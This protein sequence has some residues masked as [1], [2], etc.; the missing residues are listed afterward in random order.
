MT[1]PKVWTFF[2]GSYI[3][4]R[5]LAEV[6]F[7]PDQLEVA[8]LGGFDIEIRPRANLV[9]ST[10]GMVYGILASPTHAELDRLYAHA[11]DVL[12]ETYLPQA[13]LVETLD[14]RYVPALCYICPEMADRPPDP[15]YIDHI[16]EPA[17]AYGFPEWYLD[18]VESFKNLD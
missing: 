12:G 3:N 18:E 8:R 4:K 2:Y 15:A 16:V 9:P 6:D 11:R 10:C 5:A 1:Q 14:G 17:R 13:V 7:A